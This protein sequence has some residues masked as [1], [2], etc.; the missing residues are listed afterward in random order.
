MVSK[1]LHSL[2]SATAY[3]YICLRMATVTDSVDEDEA[4]TDPSWHQFFLRRFAEQSRMSAHV[5]R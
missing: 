3:Y 4:M 5:S 1:T 2:W